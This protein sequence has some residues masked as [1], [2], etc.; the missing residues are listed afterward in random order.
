M[1][2]MPPRSGKSELVSRRLPAYIFGLNPDASVMATSYGAD[3]ASRMNRDVQRII[4]SPKYA[5]I[6]PATTLWGKNI[7]TVSQGTYLRNSDL[8]EIVDHQ[9]VYKCS[10]VGGGITGLGFQYGIIDDPIKDRKEAESKAFREA[11]WDWYASTFY[12]RREKDARIL[13]TLT[14]WNEDD[15]AGRLLKL[16]QDD[17][18]ADQWEVISFPMI[19]EGNNKI[20]PRA[21][22]EPLWPA[23]FSLQDLEAVKTV[24]GSYE[25]AALMQQRPS[26]P[27]GNILNRNW[28]KFYKVMPTDY[29]QLIQSWDCTFKDTDGT[30]YVVGQVWAKRGADRYLVDQVR[31]RMDFPATIQAVR[32]LSAKWP[33]AV[34]K[35]I[36]DKANGPA[37]IS[38]LKR[39]ISGLIPVNPEGGKTVRVHAVSPYIE[40]GNVF[41]TR[42]LYSS[43]DSRFHRGMCYLSR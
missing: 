40:A 27:V 36:E 42:S 23:K 41:L 4:D 39:E 6:F 29:Q 16:A 10:G 38:T 14:R 15:L 13:I 1:V 24:M 33:G 21:I 37:V 5:E 30:D 7:R 12:T 20:D 32:S 25:W 11:L 35:L 2:F 31:A 19:A 9:G 26:N 8:F 22:G 28:W 18:K 3:L 43:M 34:K 17:P